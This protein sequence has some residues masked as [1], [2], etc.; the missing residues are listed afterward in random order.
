MKN[1]SDTEFSFVSRQGSTSATPVRTDSPAGVF[2]RV[3]HPRRIH[4][5]EARGAGDRVG[6]G[7]VV[8]GRRRTYPARRRYCVPDLRTT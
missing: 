4:R 8:V 3:A 5:Q 6:P 1:V 2:A 7:L